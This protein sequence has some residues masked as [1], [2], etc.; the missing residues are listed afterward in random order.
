MGC[1]RIIIHAF[2]MSDEVANCTI[3][4]YPKY[5]TP[6]TETVPMAI[7]VAEQESC[8]NC[9]SQIPIV[10]DDRQQYANITIVSSGFFEVKNGLQTYV[11]VNGVKVIGRRGYLVVAVD[12]T[13]GNVTHQRSFDTFAQARKDEA[14]ARFIRKEVPLESIILVSVK[15][16]SSRR[17]NHCLQALREIGAKEPVKTGFRGSFAMIGY[18]GLTQPSWIQQINLPPKKGP[19]EI[20]T[21]IPLLK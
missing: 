10:F 20:R 9:G 17:A 2:V 19:A 18:K 1:E 7:H 12:V 4:A 14:M 15:D 11:E 13:S 16:E 8:S 3:E 6:P 5:Y 21:L